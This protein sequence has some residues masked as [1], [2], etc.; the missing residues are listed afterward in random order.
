[1]LVNEFLEHSAEAR[2]EKVA[3]TCRGERLSFAAVEECSNAFGNAL[4]DAKLER[5]DRAA[6]FLYS[7]EEGTPAVQMGQKIDRRVMEDRRAE[8]IN[9]QESICERKSRNRIGT[10]VEVLVEGTSEETDLLLEARHE[11]MAPEIDGVVYINDGTA[12]PGD[13]V[14]VE[15]SEASTYDLVGHIISR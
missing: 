3:L 6:I 2:P 11:G 5:Q 4:L 8:L 12:D 1:M 10:T 9:A 7:D 13:F 14:K 15:I